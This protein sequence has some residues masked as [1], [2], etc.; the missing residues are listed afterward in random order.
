LSDAGEFRACTG[1]KNDADVIE[2]IDFVKHFAVERLALWTTGTD[3]WSACHNVPISQVVCRR[4]R[5]RLNS[6]GGGAHSRHA[7]PA[8]CNFPVP[9]YFSTQ[10]LLGTFVDKFPSP[11]GNEHFAPSA[12]IRASTAAAINTGYSSCC[13]RTTGGAGRRRRS[14]ARRVRQQ[15]CPPASQCSFRHHRLR[16]WLHYH[17]H[18]RLCSGRYTASNTAVY[19][20]TQAPGNTDVVRYAVR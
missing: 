6:T 5:R 11:N 14:P 9:V 10:W 3:P 13:S 2:R 4:Y 18:R 16:T 7:A 19:H 20:K 1:E 8:Q 17:C 15:R 12:R